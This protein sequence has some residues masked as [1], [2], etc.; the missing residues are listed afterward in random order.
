VIKEKGVDLVD[1]SSGGNVYKAKIPVG[2]LYQVPFADKV[3]NESGILSGAVGMI[4][5]SQQCEEILQAGKADMIFLARQLLRDPYFPLH[6]AKDLNV[7]VKWPVQY[8]RA[9]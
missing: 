9:K 7:E 8:E 4:T 3:K 5:T 6:A 1:C 2:P